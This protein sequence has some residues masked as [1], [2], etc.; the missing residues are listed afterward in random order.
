MRENELF[1]NDERGIE[2]EKEKYTCS[3]HLGLFTFAPI[4]VVVSQKPYALGL[5]AIQTF[6]RNISNRH[7]RRRARILPTT[8][9]QPDRWI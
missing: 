4:S 2:K 6:R 8:P 3:L 1:S 5:G 7:V 9:A